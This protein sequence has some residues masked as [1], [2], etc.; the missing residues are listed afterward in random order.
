MAEFFI[1]RPTV[2]IVISILFVLGGVVMIP[3]LAVSLFPDIAPP[4]ILVQTTFTGADAES[5]SSSVA[6][7]IEQRVSGVSNMAYMKSHSAND[8]TMSLRV[9]FELGTV[10][11]IASALVQNRVSQAQGS[12][13]RTVNDFGITVQPSSSAPF[14][15][16]ALYSPHGTYDSTFLSNYATIHLTDALLRVRGVGQ[17]NVF[18][19]SNYAMRIWLDPELLAA[20]GLAITEVQ[21]AVRSQN[22]VNP[23]GRIGAEPAPTGQEFTFAVRTNGR[24]STIEEFESIVVRANPDGTVVRL[25][26]V[27]KVELGTQSYNQRSLFDGKP[28]ALVV[29]FQAPGTNALEAVNNVRTT[30]DRLKAEF[31]ADLDYVVSLDTTEQ[32]RVGIEEIVHTLIEA[33]VLVLLVVY[34]FLQSWRATLIPML[35]VPV[36]LVGTFLFFPMLGFSINTL[37][38]FGLVLAI[39]LVVDDA[40][41]VVEA[42]QEQMERGLS[43]KDATVAAMKEVSGP[44]VAIALILSA[45]FI[46]A[47]FMAGVKGRLF[48]QFAVTIALSVMISAFNALSLSP[49][50]CATLLKPHGHQQQQSLLGRFFGGFNRVFDKTTTGY[51]RWTGALIRKAFITLILLAATAALSGFLGWKLPTAFVPDEDQGYMFVN[52]ELP[53]GA[54]LQRTDEVMK[55]LDHVLSQTPGV[56]HRSVVTGYSLVAQSSATYYGFGFIAFKPWAERTTADT[57]FTGIQKRIN[58]E[59]ANMP[60]ARAMAFLPPA[61]PGI[62]TSGGVTVQLQDRGGGS[63]EAFAA[64]VQRLIEDGLQQPEFAGV[65]TMF[66]STVPQVR[67]RIDPARAMQMRISLDELYKTIGTILGGSFVDN[68]NRFGR[69]WQIYLQAQGPFRA[70]PTDLEQIYVLN[71]IGERIPLSQIATMERFAGPEFVDRFNL[72]RSAEINAVPAAGVSTGQ[73]MQAMQKLVKT[74][75][76]GMGYEWSGMSFQEARAGGSAGIFALSLLFVFLILA[77]LYESWSLPFSVLLVVPLAVLG[78]FVGLILRRYN[79]DVFGQIGLIMLIGLVAKN[80]IL[81]VEFARAERLKGKEIVEAA[82]S[83]AKLRLRPILM[84]AFA[85]ILG[86]LPL[87]RATGAGAVSRRELG[88]AVVMGM[89]V[90]TLLGIF[91]TPVLFVVFERLVSK[92]APSPPESPD[93]A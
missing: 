23:A 76:E 89:S 73:A 79:F 19:A 58:R 63:P 46:P 25:R 80:A 7:S 45:V 67:I 40:I 21:N 86:A 27:A 92:R 60:E 13:P 38:L 43:P 20:R 24:L 39:G 30:M 78:A 34:L 6:T 71:Q 29:L 48:Q 11:D 14:V 31:P 3:R 4:E 81:I 54:S 36:S 88:T 8:G 50:L 70:T 12:L 69:E 33:M 37:S 44:V 56:E 77:A 18:G 15:V 74:L 93:A 41:V 75:P 47:A 53:A 28:A 72:Y 51:V 17:A 57:L 62:G 16:I 64:S 32:V 90:G 61:I 5:I 84:T 26:D 82:L 83:A 65:G 10:P 22:R 49:A 91:V 42:V 55:R 85:F 2:A 1:R 59:L 68:F 35:T 87:W 9:T 66:R 52:L